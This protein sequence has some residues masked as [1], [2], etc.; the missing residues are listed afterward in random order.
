M[1]FIEYPKCSTC[2]KAKKYLIDHKYNFHTQDI[3]KDIPTKE[4]LKKYL[5]LTEHK[6]INKFFNTSGIK[7]RELNLKDKLKNMTEEEKINLLTTDGM[8]IKRPLLIL[9]NNIIIGFKEKEYKEIK[10]Y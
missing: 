1:L 4:E 6:N 8:L 5:N 9:D 7:Y 10:Q 3:T 2:K